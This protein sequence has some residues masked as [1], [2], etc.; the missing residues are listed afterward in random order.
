MRRGGGDALSPFSLAASIHFD[1]C[2]RL[3]WKNSRI[4]NSGRPKRVGIAKDGPPP[5]GEW[6]TI[7]LN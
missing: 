7:R 6:T 3:F 4:R 5:S 1:G 2:V